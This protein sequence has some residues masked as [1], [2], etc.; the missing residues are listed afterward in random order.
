MKFFCVA[1]VSLV[2]FREFVQQPLEPTLRSFLTLQTST[3]ERGSKSLFPNYVV[4][5]SYVTGDQSAT[6]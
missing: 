1:V 3:E 6:T 4:T 5:Q 2:K